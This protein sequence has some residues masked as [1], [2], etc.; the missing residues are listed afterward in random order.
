MDVRRYGPDVGAGRAPDA[1][2]VKFGPSTA[3]VERDREI[4]V[5]ALEQARKKIDAENLQVELATRKAAVEEKRKLA[6]YKAAVIRYEKLSRQ[7][8]RTSLRCN[9]GSRSPSCVCG[10]GRQ[11]CCSWHGG[12][13][14]CPRELPTEPTPPATA[15]ES[16]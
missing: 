7:W 3:E 11:G 4:I 8:D 14:G 12:V 5:Q 1:L 2:Y 6:E 10:G 16:P 15:S 9:D 13:D